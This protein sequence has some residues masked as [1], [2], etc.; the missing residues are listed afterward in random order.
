[1]D[2]IPRQEYTSLI[3][4]CEAPLKT[5]AH[6]P[7]PNGLRAED[8]FFDKREQFDAPMLIVP[9]DYPGKTP[10]KSWVAAVKALGNWR[11]I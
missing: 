10:I 5:A 1:M 8:C 3:A 7:T 4:S 9:R 2:G 11:R 6:L